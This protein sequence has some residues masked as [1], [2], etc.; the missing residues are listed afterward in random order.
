MRTTVTLD[1]DVEQ[2]LRD[3]MHR[4]RRSFKR[5]LNDAV[6]VGLRPERGTPTGTPFTIHAW[7][8]GLLPGLDP[9]RMNQLADELESEAQLER[10]RRA[11]RAELARQHRSR[12]RRPTSAS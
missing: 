3:A 12:R 11:E 5:T 6:R 1:S 10:M 7:D 9:T 8:L 4:Q 2:L